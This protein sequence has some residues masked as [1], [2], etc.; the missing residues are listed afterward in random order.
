MADE[1]EKNLWVNTKKAKSDDPDER[2]REALQ[3]ALDATT[4]EKPGTPWEKQEKEYGRSGGV[5]VSGDRE[6][7]Y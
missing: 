4:P 7:D 1:L 5:G 2:V 6:S 3:K